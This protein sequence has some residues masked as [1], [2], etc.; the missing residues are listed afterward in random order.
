[1]ARMT[2]KDIAREAGYST[3][4]VSRVLNGSGPVSEQAAARI[5]EVVEKY[6]FQLNTNAKFLKQQ[7][8]EG[9]AV[10]IRGTNNLLFASLVE[11]LQHRV[12]DAGYNASMYYIDEND[13]EVAEAAEICQHKTPEG[14]FFLGSSRRNFQNGFAR[15]KVPSVMVTNSADGL[16]FSNLG[17]VST[18]D[19]QAAQY[20]VQHL[21]ALGHRKIGVLGGVMDQ[22]QA[23]LSRYVGA[24]FAFFDNNLPFDTNRA[25]QQGKFSVEDGYDGMMQLMDRLPDLTAVFV[26]ADVMAIGALRAIRDRGLRVPEDIS[27]ISF[28]GISLANYTIPRITTVCQN[29]EELTEESVAMLLGMIEDGTPGTYRETSYRILEGESIQPANMKSE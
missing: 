9:I 5:R 8:P 3:G 16:A 22:S 28:D 24:Q 14:I 2:I 10:I 13:D 17:S 19:T 11:Q 1:M 7:T 29:Q 6:H 25:Y 18:N 4:T 15:I 23:A 21:I 27:L 26:M 12:E 20:A